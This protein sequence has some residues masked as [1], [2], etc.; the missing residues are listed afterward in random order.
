MTSRSNLN[1]LRQLFSWD[2]TW[3]NKS[4]YKQLV[5]RDLVIEVYLTSLFYKLRIPSSYFLIKNIYFD[6]YII[7]TDLYVLK[8]KKLAYIFLNY[9]K[10]FKWINKMFTLYRLY[11]NFKKIEGPEH[12]FLKISEHLTL[13][14]YCTYLVS[15]AIYIK[16]LLLQKLV[17]SKLS[18][19]LLDFY[20]NKR[21]NLLSTIT[22]IGVLKKTQF[23]LPINNII[24]LDTTILFLQYVKL[25]V[26]HENLWCSIKIS[27]WVITW[28]TLLQTILSV[29]FDSRIGKVN[30]F[31]YKK[32]KFIF[33]ELSTIFLS[34]GSMYKLWILD[35]FLSI[36]I[37]IKI[38][39]FYTSAL[40]FSLLKMKS[41]LNDINN[42]CTIALSYKLKNKVCLI[43]SL[44]SK[45]F[46]NIFFKRISHKNN[47]T[48]SIFFFYDYYFKLFNVLSNRIEYSLRLYTGNQ[49]FFYP[50][51]FLNF[52]PFIKNSKLICEYITMSLENGL[53]INNVWKNI[54]YW[55]VD[56]QS[57]SDTI[58]SGS[59]KRRILGLSRNPLKGIRI[60]CRGPNY[61]ARRKRKFIFHS[62]VSD[63]L[64]T[65]KMPTQSF[66]TQIDFFQSFAIMKQATIGVRVWTLFEFIRRT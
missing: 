48:N 5:F 2:S 29:N 30:F 34:K 44:K 42:F 51:I 18:I 45:R 56:Q 33:S 41:V 39:F 55:V 7:E 4:F 53:S 50:T 3:Y 13:L 32:L 9:T 10:T 19:L 62:W 47:K 15:Y 65:G 63:N 31:S 61:K 66:D 40:A 16:T 8:K 37:N 11:L 28:T 35:H 36:L 27:S 12:V 20:S 46:L 25:M 17:P 52:K 1:T 49:F 57:F 54:K 24:K 64:I 43:N 21:S 14:R 38:H 23:S 58:D 22:D 26:T 6:F 60:I 59:L